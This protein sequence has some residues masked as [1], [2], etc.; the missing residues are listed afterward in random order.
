MCKP[1]LSVIIPVY[2]TENYIEECL[3]SI[4]NQTFESF[5]VLC[6]DDGSTDSSGIICEAYC[7]KDERFHVYHIE[8]SGVSAARNVGLDH[9]VG[10]YVVFID[11]D[12]FIS[13]THFETLYNGVE[14]SGMLS[15]CLREM[16]GEMAPENKKSG[17]KYSFVDF[18]EENEGIISDAL[19]NR[20]FN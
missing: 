13:A 17:Q 5:E 6:I 19:R 15:I 10:E 14:S 7:E 8:N 12:D 4:L 2:N 1:G 11:S 9:A 20:V 3:S 16:V 18:N